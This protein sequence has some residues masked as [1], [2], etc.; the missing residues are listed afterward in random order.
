LRRYNEEE[1]V[2]VAQQEMDPTVYDEQ[3][4]TDD[5]VDVSSEEEVEAEAEVEAEVEA[6]AYTR[7]LFSS[8]GAIS[9]T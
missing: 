6:G 8:T 4:I 1:D 7:S 5:E 2:A 9:D 3:S